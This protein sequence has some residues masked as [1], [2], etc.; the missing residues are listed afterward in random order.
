MIYYTDEISLRLNALVHIRG[1]LYRVRKRSYGIPCHCQ[2]V[3]FK[4]GRC[5]G[6]CTRFY[7]GGAN[8]EFIFQ[9]V[10]ESRL[11]D[12][13]LVIET[14]FQRECRESEEQQQE[15]QQII[16]DNNNED[17]SDI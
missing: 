13:I 17:S 9:E 7:N 16:K 10:N 3:M 6:F 11:K 8:R 12:D 2:C 4:D 15:Q 1:K 14:K 5:N